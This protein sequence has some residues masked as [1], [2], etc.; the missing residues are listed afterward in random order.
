VT[1]ARRA[2]LSR[3]MRHQQMQT[4]ETRN[5]TA[6]SPRP[7]RTAPMTEPNQFLHHFS[8]QNPTIST[9]PLN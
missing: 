9:L 3:A 1:H 4:A 8:R 6:P 5:S 2:V 7:P